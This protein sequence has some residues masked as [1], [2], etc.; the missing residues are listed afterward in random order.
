MPTTYP[1][2]ALPPEY[3]ATLDTHAIDAVPDPPP[4]RWLRLRDMHRGDEFTFADKTLT[5]V[6]LESPDHLSAVGLVSVAV[7]GLPVGGD[8]VA[9]LTLPAG[10]RWQMVQALRRA[11]V[12]CL[13]CGEHD[14]LGEQTYDLAKPDTRDVEA[15]CRT[16]QQVT[17]GG[18]S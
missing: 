9:L 8:G 2:I 10:Q 16:C 4:T 1:E 7:R 5:L 14:G 13:V 6:G 11:S 3:A 15:I 17:T 12:R 18:A